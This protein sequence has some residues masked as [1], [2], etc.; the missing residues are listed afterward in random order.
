MKIDKD[1]VGMWVKQRDGGYYNPPILVT[2][3]GD[4]V[5]IGKDSAGREGLAHRDKD[6]LRVPDPTLEKNKLGRS[7][8]WADAYSTKAD[9]KWVYGANLVAWV[10]KDDEEK[11]KE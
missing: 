10:P 11:S 7:L 5:F 3:V 8:I 2:H 9:A 6:W 1:H 4:R